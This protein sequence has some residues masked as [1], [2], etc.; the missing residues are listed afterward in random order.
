MQG[1]LKSE[2][3]ER[4]LSENFIGRIGCHAEGKTY[5][6]PISYA[7]YKNA[8]YA[9]TF[10]GLKVSMMRENPEV[11]F[12]TDNNHGN[13]NWESV[14]AWGTYEELKDTNERNGG[15]QILSQRVLPHNASET[16]KLSSEW[17]FAPKSFEGIEGIC[18]RIN[19]NEK[20][21]R[22]EKTKSQFK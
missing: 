11:C 13:S 20:T 14:I 7:Y 6:V 9:H 8:V 21:G 3:I 1:E 22:F 5:V 2:E 15:L 18:F 17:P 16:V 19:L 10:D 12:Q 4:L